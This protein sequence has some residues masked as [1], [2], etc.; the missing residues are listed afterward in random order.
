MFVAVFGILSLIYL[1]IAAW[2]EGFSIHPALPLVLDALNALFFF[3]AAVAMAAELGVHSC[4]NRVSSHEPAA[5]T[6]INMVTGVCPTKSYYQWWWWGRPL[7]R[8]TS[9][10]GIFMVR[11]RMLRS[12]FVLL[13]PRCTQWWRQPQEWGHSERWAIDVSSLKRTTERNGWNEKSPCFMYALLA[14]ADGFLST[15]T[16]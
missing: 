14:F 1:V 16:S 15:A 13:L 8:S 5:P 2:N 6:P 12:Q 11:I 4:G 3:C 10:N 9:S 7:S